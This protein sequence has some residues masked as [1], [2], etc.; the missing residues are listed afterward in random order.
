SRVA[1]HEHALD[2]DDARAVVDGAGHKGLSTVVVL[3]P[4]PNLAPP[5][6]TGDVAG[7]FGNRRG[8][9]RDIGER[10][11][12]LTGEFVPG[13]AGG[14]D[15]VGVVDVDYEVSRHRRAHSPASSIRAAD[16]AAQDLLRG[17]APCTCR[18]T[19]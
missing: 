9:H 5:G 11:A 1:V 3:N 15:V 17:R 16:S 8:D 4:Y 14:D 2:V 7:D 19:P 18:R 10:E 6:V 13:L 12:E